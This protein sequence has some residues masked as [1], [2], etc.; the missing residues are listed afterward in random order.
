MFIYHLIFSLCILGLIVHFL[1]FKK[2]EKLLYYISAILV[3]GT[4]AFRAD[5]LGPD[6]SNYLD[7]FLHPN[8]ISTYYQ[9][10]EIEIGLTF[11]NYLLNFLGITDKYTY[12]SIIS[13]L[14][15][16]PIIYLIYKTP[17]RFFSLFLFLSF[18]VGSSLYILSFTALRQFFALSFF[19]FI[20]YE[21][22]NNGHVIN[23][24]IV[25]LFVLM[26]CFHRSSIIVSVLYFFDK[27]NFSKKQYI[28]ILIISFIVGNLFSNYAP[29]LRVFMNQI[30]SGGYIFDN[31]YDR[32]N[33]IIPL[34]PYIGIFLIILFCL[35]KKEVNHL[36]VKSFFLIT[37][38][39]NIMYFG[40]NIDRLLA[41]YILFL[42]VT[43]PNIMNYVRKKNRT[44]YILLLGGIFIY[45]SY[46]YYF[47]LSLSDGSTE[48]ELV[49]YKSY[50]F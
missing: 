31:V 24:K 44:I 14:I 10:S 25:I 6:T 8:T 45:F 33:G 3:I 28:F 50:L 48:W 39:Y 46:K 37:V 27:I 19:C 49:P 2:A 34:I 21:Y 29:M 35:N 17:N 23:K 16:S 12:L 5:S 15:L 40:N 1:Q 20:I 36:S 7:Y 47:V 30:Y 4:V 11:V 9:V 32:K 26:L 42:V 41:Y 22:L 43:F 38:I 18:N 13:I